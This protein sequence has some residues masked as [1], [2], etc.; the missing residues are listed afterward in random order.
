MSIR[1][2][3][4]VCCCIASYCRQFESSVHY[5][6]EQTRSAVEHAKEAHEKGKMFL[7]K[8]LAKRKKE[9]VLAGKKHRQHLEKRIKA[10]LSLKQ[11]IDSSQSTM[12]A[13]QM[14]KNEQSKK[15]KELEKM[16]RE[17][18]VSEGGNPEEVFL[19][20]RRAKEFERQKEMFKAKQNE[21][22]LEIVTKLL[23][24]DKQKKRMERERSKSHS[25]GRQKP[26]PRP[27]KRNLRTVTNK[28]QMKN[29]P[30][31]TDNSK[32][33]IEIEISVDGENGIKQSNKEL[34]SDEDDVGVQLVDE[35][36]LDQLDG[37]S[38][39]V[40]EIRGQWGT[41]PLIKKKH[42]GTSQ[43]QDGKKEGVKREKSKAEVE[44]MK[45][46]MEKLKKSAI[47]KQVAGGK[48]FKVLVCVQA[49]PCHYHTAS[50]C[51]R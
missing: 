26:R 48:E 4:I 28:E 31:G 37:E 8:T 45:R 3:Y 32:D 24:E 1:A 14:L 15:M 40:P 16:E 46:A 2:K 41:A 9:E 30:S 12:Q 51:V 35:A 43:P 10:I 27:S 33:A 7:R 34:S 47:V 6:E 49:R 38:V 23:E 11:N 21:R 44:M 50:V 36:T 42:D 19:M 18:I 17:K 20:R 25:H 5:H 39:L 13:R 22:Q 29:E